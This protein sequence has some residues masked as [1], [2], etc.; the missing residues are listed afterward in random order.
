M[1]FDKG[2]GG[3]GA[4]GDDRTILFLIENGKTV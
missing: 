2:R 4:V 1:V 3:V